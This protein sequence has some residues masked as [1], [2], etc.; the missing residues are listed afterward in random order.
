MLAA[1][2]AQEKGV[3]S[4]TIAKTFQEVVAKRTWAEGLHA[5]G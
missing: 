1:R 4:F 2:I 5:V 3:F